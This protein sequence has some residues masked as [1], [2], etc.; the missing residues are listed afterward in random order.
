[1]LTA[2]NT[3]PEFRKLIEAAPP[4]RYSDEEI[5]AAFHSVGVDPELHAQ[6]R[7]CISR[8]ARQNAGKTGGKAMS[9]ELK[10]PLSFI[11]Y[12][13][14]CLLFEHGDGIAQAARL[15]RAA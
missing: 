5:I 13:A 15:M 7:C 3:W 6:V 1:V 9:Q 8:A 4:A 2:D 10:E 12:G 11:A 14:A